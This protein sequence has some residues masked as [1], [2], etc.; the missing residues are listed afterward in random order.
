MS[1]RLSNPCRRTRFSNEITSSRHFSVLA[2]RSKERGEKTQRDKARVQSV[3]A[4]CPGHGQRPPPS[5]DSVGK[6]CWGCCHGDAT[7]FSVPQLHGRWLSTWT[8]ET[9]SCGGRAEVRYR[10]ALATSF[11]EAYAS[12]DVLAS[13]RV[14]RCIREDKSFVADRRL[15]SR[16]REWMRCWFSCAFRSYRNPDV[17]RVGFWSI[18]VGRSLFLVKDS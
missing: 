12:I 3:R 1:P 11:L 2:R 6:G 9:H 14:R 7:V 13:S 18:D 5:W 15:L 17:I 8:P 16:I 10:C 4:R